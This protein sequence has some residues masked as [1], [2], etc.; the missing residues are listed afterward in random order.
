MN[1]LEK[2]VAFKRT[3]VAERKVSVQVL[4]LEKEAGFSREVLS[5]QQ[6]LLDP[7]T[8]WASASVPSPL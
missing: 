6:S 8:F 4:V 3:E 1:I 5:L 7:L 2:I